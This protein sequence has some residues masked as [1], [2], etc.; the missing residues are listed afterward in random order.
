MVKAERNAGSVNAV[1]CR[2]KVNIESGE[3]EKRR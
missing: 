3:K 1:I 2:V